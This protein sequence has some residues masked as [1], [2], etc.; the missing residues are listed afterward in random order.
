[1]ADNSHTDIILVTDG[2]SRG[3]PGPAARAYLIYENGI[4]KK[5]EGRY[6]GETT[7]NVAEYTAVLEGL[8]EVQQFHPNSVA[9]ISDSELV[10]RQLQGIYRVRNAVLSKL[11]G[12]VISILDSFP[13]YAVCHSSRENPHIRLADALCNEILDNHAQG[14]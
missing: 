8:L 14:I 12:E 10:V 7:N 5:R 6:L 3:N 1:M 13:S 9:V 11:Y 2:A 4:I